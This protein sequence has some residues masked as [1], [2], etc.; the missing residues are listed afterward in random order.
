MDPPLVTVLVPCRNAHVG[1]LA[2]A[3]ESVFGQSTARWELLVV[4]DAS[5]DPSTLEAL[6][7]LSMRGDERVRVVA[8]ASSQVTGALNTGMRLATT[9]FVCSLHCD[10]LLDEH[11][12]VTLNRAIE[13]DSG[14]DYFY[15]SRRYIDEEGR[16]L[17][18]VRPARVFRSIDAF[19][20]GSPVKH[21]HCW[22]VSAARAIGGMDESFGPHAGDDYDFA[23]S[24]AEA[25]YTFKPIPDCLYAYRDHRDHYR[26]TT[27]V[28]L[29]VQTSELARILAKHGVPDDVARA[30]I[31][32]RQ[33]LHL[34]QALYATDADRRR[35]E[36][37][38][39][40]ARA[41]WRL[42]YD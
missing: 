25:G 39:H 33:R 9:P 24:M 26:L 11:A 14:V 35:M 41:G 3:L 23:W 34:R 21:L 20:R 5:N 19:V 22:R 36:A 8:S 30:E 40:D 27:H 18:G 2:D 13:T 4:D 38:N 16:Q 7:A 31:A 37:G 12:L 17:G 6:E 42:N 15:S 1:F 32:R 10:D 28:P 29:D